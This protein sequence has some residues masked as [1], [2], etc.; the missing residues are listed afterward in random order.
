MVQMLLQF[1]HSLRFYPPQL[2][3]PVK[4][5]SCGK[6]ENGNSNKHLNCLIC[7]CISL[8]FSCWHCW[9]RE[10][11][12]EWWWLLRLSVNSSCMYLFTIPP[13][14]TV[15]CPLKVIF[16]TLWT[17]CALGFFTAGISR[18]MSSRTEA[19]C[20]ALDNFRLSDCVNIMKIIQEENH[21]S[22][23]LIKYNHEWIVVIVSRYVLNIVIKL[24]SC[25]ILIS[26]WTGSLFRERVKK[27]CL[28]PNI[29][30]VDRLPYMW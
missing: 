26:L 9:G 4:L 6:R 3:N 24:L 23:F 27:S 29:E 17:H 1:T 30:P 18:W 20:V 19:M 8:A 14:Q 25:Y 12:N 13:L 5:D 28:S 11:R 15:S 7:F 2:W 22:T 16:K 21:R 10:V